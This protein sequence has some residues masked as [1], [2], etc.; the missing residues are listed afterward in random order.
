MPQSESP[1]E[2]CERMEHE[3]K[4]GDDAYRYFQMKELWRKREDEN[5]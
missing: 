1:S 5:K 4:D 3:A 2:W